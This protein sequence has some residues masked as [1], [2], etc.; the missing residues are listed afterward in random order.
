M[1]KVRLTIQTL[2]L[3][4]GR[5]IKTVA[6]HKIISILS[7]IFFVCTAFLLVVFLPTLYGRFE[8]VSRL[9]E[10]DS[11]YKK[12][13]LVTSD[14]SDVIIRSSVGCGAR[15]NMELKTDEVCDIKPSVKEVTM[16]APERSEI[17]GVSYTF[18]SWEGC[19]ASNNDQK[20]CL[21]RIGNATQTT[22]KATY[23][24]SSQ[25]S[26][27]DTPAIP[28]PNDTKPP[29]SYQRPKNLREECQETKVVDSQN[30]SVK[31]TVDSYYLMLGFDWPEGIEPANQPPVQIA[32][33]ESN[34]M[35]CKVIFTYAPQD[36]DPLIIPRGSSAIINNIHKIGAKNPGPKQPSHIIEGALTDRSN[37]SVN[38]GVLVVLSTSL[39]F[40]SEGNSFGFKDYNIYVPSYQR[41][42]TYSDYFNFQFDKL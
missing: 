4:W 26:G 37:F 38:Y 36:T 41:A 17:R 5:T 40:I 29:Y 6:S 22:I 31:C 15:Q 39:G 23:I 10:G 32:C 2:T 33:L 14:I 20:I 8:S 1:K 9:P 28:S 18:T 30:N 12:S 34:D 42:G 7:L 3:L 19:S 13:V 16:I 24:P 35:D 11:R 25:L 27:G 21:V